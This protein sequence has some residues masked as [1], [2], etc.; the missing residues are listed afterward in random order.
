MRPSITCIST[1]CRR[2]VMPVDGQRADHRGASHR[3]RAPAVA[4]GLRWLATSSRV[5]RS[6]ERRHASRAASDARAK[7]PCPCSGS[8]PRPVRPIAVATAIGHAALQRSSSLR[9]LYDRQRTLPPATTDTTDLIAL[10]VA[11]PRAGDGGRVDHRAAAGHG[12]MSWLLIPLMASHLLWFR[13]GAALVLVGCPVAGGVARA[14]PRAST[15]GNAATRPACA[16]EEG[17]NLYRQGD[18]PAAEKRSPGIDTTEGFTT[19]ATRRRNAAFTTMPVAALRPRAA[20]AAAWRTPSPIA[21]LST[22]RAKRSAFARRRAGKPGF[23]QRW[24]RPVIGCEGRPIRRKNPTV[25][26]TTPLRRTLRRRPPGK[27][28]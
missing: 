10:D 27:P 1:T 24:W 19:W 23:R 12:A 5:H 11:S 20:P 28:G 8:A 22:P 4:G 13:R 17:R 7:P 6:R 18:Y 3:R 15:G 25:S 2:R 21:P 14:V 9:A 26:R 16:Y